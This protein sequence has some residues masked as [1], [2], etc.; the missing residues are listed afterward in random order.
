MFYY[1]DHNDFSKINFKEL[2]DFKDYRVGG[3]TGYFYNSDFE[4][5]G[6]KLLYAN[7]EL[8]NIKLLQQGDIGLFP[9]SEAV[10]GSII[11]ENFSKY[12]NRFQAA[13]Y[14]VNESGLYLMVSK[15]YPKA[16][17]ITIEFNRELKKLK[18]EGFVR[19]I[20]RKYGLK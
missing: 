18:E 20:R 11:S 7:T 16:K 12:K 4:N 5:A 17:K 19:K 15:K 3:V 9:L 2:S 1:T 13:N 10:A 14:V 8:I 6:V